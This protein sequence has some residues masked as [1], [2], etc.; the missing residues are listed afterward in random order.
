MGRSRHGTPIGD[1]RKRRGRGCRSQSEGGAAHEPNH[2]IGEVGVQF[3]ERCATLL[4]TLE[5]C[6]LVV[7]NQST[8]FKGSASND[9]SSGSTI[10]K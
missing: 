2:C 3:Q 4:T 6:I 5:A 7:E 1:E 8:I 10:R 9:P